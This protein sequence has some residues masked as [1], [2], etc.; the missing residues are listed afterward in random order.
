MYKLPN[1]FLRERFTREIRKHLE[2][3]ENENQRLWHIVKLVLK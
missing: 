3:N 1:A 2:M